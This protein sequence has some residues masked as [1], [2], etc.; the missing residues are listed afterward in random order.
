[1]HV[2]G[3]RARPQQVLS[4]AAIQALAGAAL[5][6]LDTLLLNS[7][8]K[9]GD[10]GLQVIAGAPWAA[11]LR[12]LGVGGRDIFHSALLSA[13]PSFPRLAALLMDRDVSLPGWVYD[14]EFEVQMGGQ[15][16]DTSTAAPFSCGMHHRAAVTGPA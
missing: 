13:L 7:Y 12:T 2:Q 3:A 9:I 16:E 4:S 8:E 6:A 5:P 10:G 14:P 15:G 1:M 11:Q